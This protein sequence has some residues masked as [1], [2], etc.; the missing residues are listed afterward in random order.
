[1]FINANWDI[2]LDTKLIFMETEIL[3]VWGRRIDFEWISA[4]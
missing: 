4:S 2:E 1:M 3:L